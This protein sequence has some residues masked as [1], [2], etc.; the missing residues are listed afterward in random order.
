MMITILVVE[1]NERLRRLM[2]ITL[3]NAGYTVLEAGN[4]EEALAVLE[5]TPV[6]L[7]LLDMLMPVMD[8]LSF[9][10]AIQ[11][12]SDHIPTLV[13]TA[14]GLDEDKCKALTLG[15]DGYILKPLKMAELLEHVE[16]FLHQQ[17]ATQPQTLTIGS[18]SLFADSMT[19]STHGITTQLSKNEFSLLQL[20]LLHPGK[21]FTRQALMAGALGYD[22]N[23]LETLDIQVRFLQHNYTGNPDF[24]IETVPGL[25]Y[26]AVV[27]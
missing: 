19:T 5:T 7:I 6:S 12:P 20:L 16:T 4:G 14:N 18:T 2:V 22:G 1:D 21:I 10:K 11:H 24:T 8:G 9:L 15:A 26:R 17:D 3:M 27:K 25:G 23:S 13:I